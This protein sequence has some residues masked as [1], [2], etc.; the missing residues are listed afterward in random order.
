MFNALKAIFIVCLFS[1]SYL[2]QAQEYRTITG[3]ENNPNNPELGAVKTIQPRWVPAQFEDDISAPNGTNRTNPRVVSN[4]IFNQDDPINNSMQLSD[5]LWVFGQFVDHD[6]TLVHNDASEYL[7]VVIPPEDEYYIPGSSMYFSRAASMPETGT[8]TDNPRAYLN[9]VTSFIDASNV[10]GSDK[11]RAKWLRTFEDGKLRTSHGDVLPWNTTTGEFNDPKSSTAPF[12]ADDVHSGTKLFVA[13]D[14]RANENPLLISMHTLFV[15]DHNRICDEIKEKYPMLSDEELYQRARKWVGAY[16]Q[17]ITYHEWLPAMGVL[18]TPYSGYNATIDP[19]ISTIF[20]T[21]AFRFGHTLINEDIIRMDNAG[22]ELPQGSMKLSHGYFNPT[23]VVLSKGVE[24]YL[25]GMG[26]QM[27]QEL[28]CKMIH[29]LR[30]FLFGSPENG[31]IDLA[32]ANI[33]RGR[34]KGIPDFN[35]VRA[36]L[37]L[38]LIQSFSEL[39]RNSDEA[40]KLT[41]IYGG[42]DNVDP[43][44]GM[45]AEHHMPNALFGNTI[46]NIVRTQ[47]EN[48]RDGDRFYFE[49]DDFFNSE[50]VEA[51]KNTTLYDIIMRNTDIDKM[52]KNVFL[53]MPHESIPEGPA[54][55]ALDF[56][57][58]LYPNPTTG[59]FTM[60]V[61]SELDQTIDMK[62][63]NLDAKLVLTQVHHLQSGENFIDIDLGEACPRGVY[64]IMLQSDNSY[65]I[66]KLVKEY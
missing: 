26:T 66:S 44:V 6:I 38:P 13:G 36:Q 54:L 34:E 21:A 29:G 37:G 51:L 52:Q 19:S 39:T 62:I 55:L 24:T 18:M 65:N 12:M 45:L 3:V 57:M 53:T 43:W 7:N 5:Y 28:D 47:F 32:T 30:N 16:L 23:S 50:E 40:N 48:L 25:V 11:E 58:A 46:M 31:G 64:N 59:P 9:E 27:Q 63:Y 56:E 41:F 61:F 2:V 20:S 10:Y 42:M 14:I 60:K 15:R 33:V 35:T 49:N 8:D 17:A 22:N 1:F 4:Y